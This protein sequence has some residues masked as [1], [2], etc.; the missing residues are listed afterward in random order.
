MPQHDRRDPQRATNWWHRIHGALRMLCLLVVGVVALGVA[1]N[2]A[3]AKR[4]FHRASAPAPTLA[5]EQIVT[6]GTAVYALSADH[7][8]VYEWSTH[9]DNW[10]K[11]FGPARNIYAGGGNL[12]ATDQ[13]PGDI[14]KYAGKPGQWNRIG[15]PGLTFVA[16][17]EKVYGV[18]PDSSGVWE[19]SG[20]GDVWARIGGPAKNLYAGPAKDVRRSVKDLNRRPLNTLYKTDLATGDLYKYDGKPDQWTNVGSPGA[21]FAVTD[22]NLY[23][24]TPDRSAVVERD[25]KSGKWKG[26]GGPAGDIFSSNTLYKTDKVTGDLYKYNGKP[27]RWNR[28]GG[29]A[30]AFATSGDYLYRLSSDRRSVQKYNGNGA[31]DQWLDLRAPVTPATRA[32]KIARLTALT[33]FGTDATNAWYREYGAHRTGKPDRYEFRWTTNVCNSPAPNSIGSYDFT[34]ACVRHDFGYRNYRDLFG[35]A[36]FRDNPTGKQR[37]DQIFLQ[38]LNQV[39]DQRGWPKA[40]TPSDRA[41]CKAAA[42][43]YF[44]VVVRFG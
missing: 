1:A 41:A 23:G 13:A 44:G 22:E 20:K 19:Y 39:C 36:A 26:V 12:Y 3:P 28:I 2:A 37:I 43:T 11:V 8:G 9:Q 21:T 29:P 24:L 31:T 16:T 40:Y 34:L 35:E 4:Q 5:M 18:S 25:T 7:Q 17:G 33:Q 15:G 6:T 30:A 42:N 32:E 10:I 38:D 27:G 14:H